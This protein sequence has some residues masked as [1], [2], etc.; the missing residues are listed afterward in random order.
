MNPGREA[1]IETQRARV[2]TAWMPP[3]GGEARLGKKILGDRPNNDGK[4]FQEQE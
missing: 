3:T 2:Y 4:A 1:F